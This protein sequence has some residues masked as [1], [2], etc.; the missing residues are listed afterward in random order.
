[1]EDPAI[2]HHQALTHLKGEHKMSSGP[3]FIR[4]DPNL[5]GESGAERLARQI[6]KIGTF[7]DHIANRRFEKARNQQANEVRQQQNDLTRQKIALNKRELDADHEKELADNEREGTYAS[8]SITADKAYNGL[9]DKFNK[10]GSVSMEEITA[11]RNQIIPMLNDKKRSA[12]ATQRLQELSTM[13]QGIRKNQEDIES[14]SYTDAKAN[15]NAY[16]TRK[17]IPEEDASIFTIKT[18][19]RGRDVTTGQEVD[20]FILDRS[21]PNPN[22]IR[23]ARF[24]LNNLQESGGNLSDL[25]PEDRKFL[26][27]VAA[28]DGI[29]QQINALTKA[30]APVTARKVIDDE[31]NEVDAVVI[32]G[33]VRGTD[34]DGK[35]AIFSR[36]EDIPTTTSLE[37]EDQAKNADGT[38]KATFIQNI[39]GREILWTRQG[40]PG[41]SQY[42]SRVLT[43]TAAQRADAKD[44]KSNLVLK[45]LKEGGQGQPEE[46]EPG[47]ISRFVS[48]TTEAAL[49]PVPRQDKIA[50]APS[51]A[52][53]IPTEDPLS[54]ESIGDAF[55]N[56]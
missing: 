24:I 48:G 5:V 3:K 12:A 54:F 41:S 39:D 21:K 47:F 40:E 52:S 31:G 16:E 43:E 53:R 51:S 2:L 6:N 33:Q 56:D 13:E 28:D 32:N 4:P 45:L 17:A 30:G 25:E 20:G 9:F 38:F 29:N 7:F 55:G 50:T 36:K 42:K 46:D 14:S 15:G 10:D 37:N 27:K 26:F 23:E 22:A 1:M 35:I 19:T 49:F 44:E 18:A 34:E 8:I 11:T